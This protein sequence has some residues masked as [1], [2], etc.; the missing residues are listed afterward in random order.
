MP[1]NLL[2]PALLVLIAGALTAAQPPT[3][4]VLARAGGSVVFAALLSFTV[5]TLVLAALTALTQP[6][7]AFGPLRE[8]PWWA[9]AGGFYGAFFVAVGAYAAP[10]LGIASM[11]TIGVAGSMVGALVLDHFGAFG[12]ERTPISVGRLFGVALV[13]AGVVLVR[14]F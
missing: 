1:T 13:I 6:R 8:V 2:L 9:W 5:G 12:L 14:R 3:N 7:I 11:V 4:A 10:K